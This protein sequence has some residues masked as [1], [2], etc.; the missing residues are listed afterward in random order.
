MADSVASPT[1]GSNPVIL[2]TGGGSGIGA[3]VARA[4][5]AMSWTVVICGRRSAVLEQ[6]ADSPRIHP[7]VTD[8]TDTDAVRTMVDGIVDRFGRIDGIVLNAGLV[9]S[10]PVSELSERDWSAMLETNLTAPYRLLHLTLPHLVKSQGAVVGV[11]S[12][13]ALR[14]SEGNCGYNATK[15]GLN[16]LLQSVA[17]DYGPQGVRA[18][19]VC[20]GWTRT[21]MADEEMADL[22]QKH[23]LDVDQAYDLTTSLTPLS[24]PAT[25]AEVAAVIAWLLSPAAS[26]VNA[27]VLPVDGGH[28]AVDVGTVAF[29]S[30]FSVHP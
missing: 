29:N 13:G 1:R 6:V 20:P 9:R 27:A 3:A 16:M 25:S 17:V 23:G 7:V 22:A 2:I 5:A 15:A 14:A 26:Y 30:R 28:S 11:S 21:E 4:L 10:A 8:I 24:R 18:N 19:V 12:V